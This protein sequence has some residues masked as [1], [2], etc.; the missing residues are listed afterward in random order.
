MSKKIIS[1]LLSIALMVGFGGVLVASAAAIK[2]YV[3]IKQVEAPAGLKAVIE[4]R[5]DAAEWT[6]YAVVSVTLSPQLPRLTDDVI[7]IYYNG[8]AFPV[9]IETVWDNFEPYSDSE[10][11]YIAVKNP[12][13]SNA[14]V[15][16]AS[17]GLNE[18]TGKR[19]EYTSNTIFLN[20]ILYGGNP[21]Q[22][23]FAMLADLLRDFFNMILGPLGLAA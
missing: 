4:E 5:T 20:N 2:G 1:I 23:F 19:E 16:I 12:E 18:T 15:R 10:G 3:T 14:M 9:E 11:L 6:N 7:T 8:A 17:V 22:S 21:F 13:K